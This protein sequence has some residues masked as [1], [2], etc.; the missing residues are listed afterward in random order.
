MMQINPW[1][2][3]VTGLT[4]QALCIPIVLTLPE[5]LS[6]DIKTSTDADIQNNGPSKNL[7][8]R[9]SNIIKMITLAIHDLET[10]W[11]DWRLIL[12]VALCPFRMMIG[13]LSDLLQR[14][15]SNRYEWTLANATFLYSLQGTI[16]SLLLFLLLPFVT[17]SIQRS[18]YLSSI[19]TNVIISRIS[20]CLLMLGYAM[21]GLAPT[22]ILLILG[23]L[24]ESLGLGLGSAL[25]ALTGAL[26]DRKYNARMFS[27]IG[28]A[29]TFARMIIYPLISVLFNVGLRKGGIWLG[30]PYDLIAVI[31]VLALIPMT[32]LRFENIERLKAP[33]SVA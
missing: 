12:M 5:T 6:R 32:L 9:I 24:T 18:F 11:T 4:L 25:R 8:K 20:L 16:S 17:D 22:I 15:V 33:Y 10:I 13:S 27:T 26:I 3:I 28:I 14:Y 1:I 2:A 23:L 30:L 19:Q 29:E 31:A 7:R 21:I